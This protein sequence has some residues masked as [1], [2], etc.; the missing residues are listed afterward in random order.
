MKAQMFLVM[1]Y[2]RMTMTLAEV[3]EE[4]S[5]EVGTAHN[6]ISAGTFPIP[7]RKE[8]R[9]RVADVRDVGDYLDRQRQEAKEAYEIRH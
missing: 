6:K 2:E 3:C 7:T 4:I 5:L 8:G 1:K 9:N